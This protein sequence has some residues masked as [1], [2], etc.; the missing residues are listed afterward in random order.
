MKRIIFLL[1]FSF[2]LLQLHTALAQDQA[3]MMKAYQAF[4]TPGPMHKLM[5]SWKGSWSAD[6]TS[7]M[8][9]KTPPMK[10]TATVENT[11]ALNGLYQMGHYIGTMMGAPFEGYSTLAYDNAKK[12]FVDTWVDNM[13][14]GVVIMM[15]TWN[16][17]TKTLSLSGTQTN[18]MTGKDSPIR[19][20]T[21][22][23]D[24]NT[25]KMTMYG[26][27]MDGKEMKFMEATMKRAM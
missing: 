6:V 7:W 20:E 10:S 5:D 18:A 26:E 9:P 25:Q 3:A 27:G 16:D 19:Q 23:I 17:K 8:D 22:L 24:A 12:M 15:G 14:S 11:M 21:K 2:L 1:T 4:A 13:G